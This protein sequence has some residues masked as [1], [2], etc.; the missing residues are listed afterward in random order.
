MPLTRFRSSAL[1]KGRAAIMRAA[2]TCPI[3]GTVVSSFSVA[4][5][6]SILPSCVFSFARLLTSPG[7]IAAANDLDVGV[8]EIEREASGN[9]PDC[10]TYPIRLLSGHAPSSDFL[11]LRVILQ[12]L[13]V[14]RVRRQ[15]LNLRA[16]LRLSRG[17][18]RVRWRPI[19]RRDRLPWFSQIHRFAGPCFVLILPP[20]V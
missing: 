19:V 17:F 16:L 8:T 12:F 7:L 4:V 6:M 14:F 3:P 9:D 18:S 20:T 10:K 2:I 15:K 5:L 11:S 1:R 13:R